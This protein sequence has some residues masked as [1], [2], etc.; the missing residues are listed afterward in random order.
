MTRFLT[1]RFLQAVISIFGL[2]TVVFFM[3][4][5]TGDPVARM[6][7]LEAPPE[8]QESLRARFGLDKP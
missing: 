3:M 4:R 8:V 7:P 6:I 1:G 5:L 2:V